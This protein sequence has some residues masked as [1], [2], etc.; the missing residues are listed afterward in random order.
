MSDTPSEVHEQAFRAF[1]RRARD[2]LGKQI[3]ELILFGSVARGEARGIDSDVDV[4]V[5][6]DSKEY[7]DG[8]REI[9]YDVQLEYG[10]VLSLHTKTKER[11]EER[12]DHPFVRNVLAEGRS[13]DSI[14][15]VR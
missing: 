4:F 10:V 8:L 12:K 14:P 13:Y 7:Q 11:F 1:A 6:L 15:D 9:A 2:E 5:V 3:H